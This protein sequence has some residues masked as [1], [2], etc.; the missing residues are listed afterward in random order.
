MGKLWS[1]PNKDVKR[2]QNPNWKGGKIERICSCKKVFYVWKCKIK[3]GRGKYCSKKCLY[4][5]SDKTKIREQGLKNR[6]R[7]L[8]GTNP[9]FKGWR[10]GVDGYKLIRMPSHPFNNGGYIR[11][12]RLV[13]EKHIGRYLKRKEV[14]HHINHNRLDNRIENLQLMTNSSLHMKTEFTIMRKH[15]A[16]CFCKCH[17]DI[18]S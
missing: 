1:Q 15:F 18:R 17:N 2:E 11:E 5:Y 4:K 14:V 12:H 6:G 16:D 8:I 9:R 13:M 7:S 10:I 3:D